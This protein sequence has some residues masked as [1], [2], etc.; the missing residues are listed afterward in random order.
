M[1]DRRRAKA[2]GA[3]WA[4]DEDTGYVEMAAK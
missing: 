4:Q 1:F 2:N 3:A